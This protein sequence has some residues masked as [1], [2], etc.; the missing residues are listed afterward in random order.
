MN[1][2][3]RHQSL[4]SLKSGFANGHS[5]F[6][7][8]A[9]TRQE[10]RIGLR[11]ARCQKRRIGDWRGTFRQVTELMSSKCTNSALEHIGIVRDVSRPKRTLRKENYFIIT[12]VPPHTK[13]GW[14]D[15]EKDIVSQVTCFTAL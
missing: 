10:K 9:V 12:I 5:F 8:K 1:A 13:G 6:A 4:T 7:Y 14:L 2:I 3:I 15:K 11:H